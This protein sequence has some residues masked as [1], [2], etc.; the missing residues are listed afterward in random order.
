[1]EYFIDSLPAGIQCYFNTKSGKI[2][3]FDDRVYHGKL[4]EALTGLSIDEAKKYVAKHLEHLHIRSLD[5]ANA[6]A[7][8]HAVKGHIRLIWQTL[9]DNYRTK[10]E[11][12]GDDKLREK[13][14]ELEKELYKYEKEFSEIVEE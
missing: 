11:K 6:S 13:I 5:I 14:S 4:S 7:K 1:M 2:V 8:V 12:A 9:S 10:E 3:A